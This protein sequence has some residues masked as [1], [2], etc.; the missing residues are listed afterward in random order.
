MKYKCPQLI[1][2]P[3]FVQ[4]HEEDESISNLKTHR[5]W[6]LSRIHYVDCTQEYPSFRG[7]PQRYLNNVVPRH[8]PDRILTKKQ[9]K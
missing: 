9:K 1:C 5:E 2:Q 4:N 7:K 8:H 3:V 6:L